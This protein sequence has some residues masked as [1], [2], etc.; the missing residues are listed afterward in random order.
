MLCLKWSFV[1]FLFLGTIMEYSQDWQSCLHSSCQRLQACAGRTRRPSEGMQ[2]PWNNIQIF[3]GGS[4]L[5]DST[6]FRVFGQNGMISTKWWTPVH[7][8]VIQ[9]SW[10]SPPVLW[11]MAVVRSWNLQST[12]DAKHNRTLWR[13]FAKYLILKNVLPINP[14][15]STSAW[16]PFHNFHFTMSQDA[17]GAEQNDFREETLVFYRLIYCGPVQFMLFRSLTGNTY[18]HFA[19]FEYNRYSNKI[20]WTSPDIIQSKMLFP[21]IQSGCFNVLTS[22]SVNDW[23]D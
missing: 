15:F 3:W 20:L 7:I 19:I 14:D 11:N 13:P 18:W 4:C 21:F 16:F 9:F 6:F 2:R 10:I 23:F 1:L 17:N 12:G 5:I 22:D 8:S